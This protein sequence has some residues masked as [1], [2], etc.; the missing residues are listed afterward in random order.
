MALAVASCSFTISKA[1][2]S[3][4]VREWIAKRNHWLGELLNCPYCTSHWLTF[5][6]VFAYR[7]RVILG[8]APLDYVV[9]VFVIVTMANVASYLM[10]TLIGLANTLTSDS[11]QIGE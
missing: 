5:G 9:T 6:L 3:V 11:Q 2:I 10:H 4:G 1:K 8:W 7:A